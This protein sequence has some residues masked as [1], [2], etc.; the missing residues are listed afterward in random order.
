MKETELPEA[1]S[2]ELENY[3]PSFGADFTSKVMDKIENIELSAY[4]IYPKLIKW[5]SI[6]GA[7]AVIALML[8]IYLS[9]GTVSSDA[10]HGILEFS[11]DE[12][13]IAYL[14]N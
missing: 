9:E 13:T 1:F 6:S 3:K 10:I 12:P 4:S 7:A 11:P 8:M 2:N 5:V 14:D